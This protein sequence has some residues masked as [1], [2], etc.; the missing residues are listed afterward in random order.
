M[1]CPTP[2]SRRPRCTWASTSRASTGFQ[3]GWDA[4]A[5]RRWCRAA[6]VALRVRARALPTEQPPPLLP[7]QD[8]TGAKQ[9]RHAPSLRRSTTDTVMASCARGGRRTWR[10]QVLRHHHQPPDR[11]AGKGAGL[12]LPARPRRLLYRRAVAT[13]TPLGVVSDGREG[14]A[15]PGLPAD[16]CPGPCQR[17]TDAGGRAHLPVSHSLRRGRSGSKAACDRLGLGRTATP[18][19]LEPRDCRPQPRWSGRTSLHHPPSCKAAF[20]SAAAPVAGAA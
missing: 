11:I 7:R 8:R 13:D 14:V 19:G 3:E 17:A 10:R 12:S 1:S 20:S 16:D 5:S 15:G 4:P 9:V 2:G 6:R 18:D